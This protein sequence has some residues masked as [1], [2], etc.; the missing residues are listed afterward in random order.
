MAPINNLGLLHLFVQDLKIARLSIRFGIQ[1]PDFNNA[2]TLLRTDRHTHNLIRGLLRTATSRCCRKIPRKDLDRRAPRYLQTIGTTADI[3]LI[4]P[5]RR[6]VLLHYP[7]QTVR[8]F[9]RAELSENSTQSLPASALLQ[10]FIRGRR[11]Q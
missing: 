6:D 8:C 10:E 4:L 2:E 1:I 11:P 3:R 7:Q 9:M 5:Q